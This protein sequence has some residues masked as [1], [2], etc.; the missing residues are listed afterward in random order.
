MKNLSTGGNYTLYAIWTPLRYY[1][2]FDGQGADDGE[3]MDTMVLEGD[4][5]ECF[6]PTKNATGVDSVESCRAM[7]VARDLRRLEAAGVKTPRTA[8]GAPA[9][10]VEIAPE[11]AIDDADVA[12]YVKEHGI[13]SI[14]PGARLV[15][16]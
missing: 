8:D 5:A 9:C 3:T 15:L 14:A 4:R 11:A 1:I 16:E 2:A 12:Q 13:S 6:A 7:L 10:L